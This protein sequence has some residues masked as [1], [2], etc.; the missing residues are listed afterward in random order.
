MHV[1][2]FNTKKPKMQCNRYSEYY[3][4]IGTQI[5]TSDAPCIT[6]HGFKLQFGFPITYI[7]YKKN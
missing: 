1:I 3:N 7:C 6:Y 4:M 2:Q 5:I